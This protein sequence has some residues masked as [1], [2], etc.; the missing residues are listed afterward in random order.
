MLDLCEQARHD[1]NAFCEFIG[2]GPGG[3]RLRQDPVHREWQDLWEKN[4]RSVLLAPVGH[5]KTTQLRHRLLWRIGQNPNLQIAYVS[6][7]ERHPKKVAR[8]FKAEIEHNRRVQYVFPTLKPGKVWTASEFE[9]QRTTR[10]PDPTFQVFGAFSQ[11]VLGSRADIV[12]FDDLCNDSNTLTDYARQRMDEWVAEV[13][14]RLKPTAE[15][16][17]IGHIWHEHDQLQRWARLRSWAYKRYEATS[18]AEGYEEHHHGERSF[19]DG[20]DVPLAPVVMSLQDIATKAEELGPVRTE[21]MLYNRLASRA[22]GRFRQ[23]WFDRCLARG[24]GL[25][26]VQ[27]SVGMPAYT[28]VDLGHR[29]ATG[30]DLTVLFTIG[31]LPDGTRQVL[32]IRSGLW[33]APEILHQIKL[34]NHAYGSIVAVE[35]N[36]AQNYLLDFAEDLECL[37]V[38]KHNTNVNK[39]DLAHGVESLG[40]EMSQG[41]WILPCDEH[42]VPNEE[43]M[44]FINGC[45]VYDPTRHASDH[46]MAAWIAREAARL[47]PAAL[48]LEIEPVDH[49][50][51]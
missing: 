2:E 33:S 1:V 17:A 20:E 48:A 26:F 34:V 23:S 51:R 29:K 24:R 37:P 44:A 32:D 25:G 47:S 22:L 43:T 14:S 19:I 39:H 9:V 7:T 21:M 41:R 49:L 28:G 5:G 31:I 12:V 27:S 4:R 50:T 16:M 35:N 45:L 11:S 8:A 46:L 42:L 18:K 38:R 36:G 40:H 13:I 30:S 6:A 15:V 3:A 10:D